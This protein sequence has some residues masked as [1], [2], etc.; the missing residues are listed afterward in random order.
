MIVPQF[1]AT[2]SFR[3]YSLDVGGNVPMKSD[4]ID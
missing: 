1:H 3:L 2:V 4:R